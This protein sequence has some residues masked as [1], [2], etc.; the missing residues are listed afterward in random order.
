MTERHGEIEDLRIKYE[1]PDDNNNNIKYYKINNIKVWSAELFNNIRNP[2]ERSKGSKRRCARVR[3]SKPGEKKKIVNYDKSIEA[4]TPHTR[5]HT[6]RRRDRKLLYMVYRWCVTTVVRRARWLGTA[7]MRAEVPVCTMV[8]WQTKRSE[9][10]LPRRRHA[11]R[12]PL[13]RSR[14]RPQQV[15]HA[16]THAHAGTQTHTH[17]FG[18]TCAFTCRVHTHTLQNIIPPSPTPTPMLRDQ[19]GGRRLYCLPRVAR[20]FFFLVV[21]FPPQRSISFTIILLSYNIPITSH[22][23]ILR[24]LYCYIIIIVYLPWAYYTEHT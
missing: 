22:H 6:P 11:G 15:P 3:R 16:R 7:T 19:G 24:A 17:Q 13:A 10:R 20:V 9:H 1:N 5:T 14:G 23:A 2:V 4:Q 21:F 8:H 18:V 12:T